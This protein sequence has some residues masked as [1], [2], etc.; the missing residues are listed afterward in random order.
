MWEM[1]KHPKFIFVTGGTVSG[2]GK[3][4][5]VASFPRSSN[6][7]E[8]SV[9]PLKIDPYLNKDAGTM[10][11]YQH[12]EV[13]RYGRWREETDLDPPRTL[14]RFIGRTCPAIPILRPAPFMKK[15]SIRNDEKFFRQDHQIIPHITDRDKKR[16][17]RRS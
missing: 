16:G 11:P 13:F 10:N 2:L 15:S 17:N 6:P 3:G 8:I 14:R 7:V 12:G 1:K 9:L 4:V 5:T